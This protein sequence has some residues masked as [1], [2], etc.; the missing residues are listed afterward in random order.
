MTNAFRD[1]LV[2]TAWLADHLDDPSLRLFDC[3]GCIGAGYFNKGRE[4]HYDLHHIPGA[5]FLDVANPKGELTDPEATLPFTWPK[6]AQFEAAMGRLGVDNHCHVILYA[7][8]NPDVPGSGIT[9]VTRAWWLMHHYGVN[10]AILDG[11]WQKWI[12][13]NR[14][15]SKQR[16][17]YT[18]TH[19]NAA[20]DWENGLARK[21]DVLAAVVD[22]TSCI[23][24]SL[25]PESYRGDIDRNYGTFGVRKGHITGA[26]NVHYETLTDAESGCFKNSEQLRECFQEA[27]VSMMRPVI[28]YCGGGIGATAPGFALKLLGKHDVKIY[29]GSLWEWANDPSLPMTDL[30]GESITKI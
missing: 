9:W 20:P 4:K 10:C 15:V 2:T 26:R 3:T 14:P 7:G 28:T 23:V 29:D 13:E 16:N 21:A 11:G 27:G 24:D 25:S 19:F 8:P 5:V 1:Y 22:H 30:T 18:P 17:D 6:P 12:A